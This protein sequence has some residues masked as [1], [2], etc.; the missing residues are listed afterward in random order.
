MFDRS[1]RVNYNG[2]FYKWRKIIKK[3]L[4]LKSARYN[5]DIPRYTNTE[6]VTAIIEQAFGTADLYLK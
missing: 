2:N 1:P 4:K 5:I 6:D 3:Y